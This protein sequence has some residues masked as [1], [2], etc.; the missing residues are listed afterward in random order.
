MRHSIKPTE[1]GVVVN[2]SSL[3]FHPVC[4]I[5]PGHYLI[6]K[7]K[8]ATAKDSRTAVTRKKVS[9]NPTK[10]HTIRKFPS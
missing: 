9:F 3:P 1:Y 4:C 5:L 10:Y 2:H 8:Q 7:G 6:G